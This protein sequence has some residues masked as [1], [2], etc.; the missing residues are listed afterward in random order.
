MHGR[1]PAPPLAL[2]TILDWCTVRCCGSCARPHESPS[3]SLPCSTQPL[4]VGYVHAVAHTL[5]AHFGTPHGVGNA[6]VLPHVLDFYCQDDSCTQRLCELAMAIGLATEH[7][8]AFESLAGKRKLVRDRAHASCGHLHDQ[9]HDPH[10]HPYLVLC[11][12]MVRVDP[13]WV[14]SV[15]VPARM[16]ARAFVAKVR[17]LNSEMGIP[18]SVPDMRPSDVA[19]VAARA[20]VEANGEGKLSL[21]RR[22]LRV[23]ISTIRIT[24]D[25]LRFMYTCCDTDTDTNYLTWSRYDFGYPS[26]KYMES[27]DM[28]QVVQALLPRPSAKL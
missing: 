21:Y 4:Q 8:G 20:I 5:G 1:S 13:R 19:P 14:V 2:C 24:L 15:R 12:C 11:C 28:L 7:P 25:W 10:P 22:R 18:A 6:M 3:C 9:S 27:M 23:M 26:P 17:A 16:Q